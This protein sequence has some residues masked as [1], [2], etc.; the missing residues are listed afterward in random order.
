MAI[1]RNGFTLIELMIVVVVV[2]ILAAIALPAY[3]DFIR[4]GRRAEALKILMDL[5]VAEENYRVNNSGYAQSLNTLVGAT[6]AA[7]YNASDHYTFAVAASVTNPNVYILQ[8][9]PKGRQEK[10]R[11]RGAACGGGTVKLEIDQNSNKTPLECW[12]K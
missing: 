2:G 3:Q 11:E 1:K 6:V 5:Q 10:D 9:D 12:R 4:K 7:N 8:A